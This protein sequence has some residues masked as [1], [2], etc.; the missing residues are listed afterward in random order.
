MLA[1]F[2][3]SNEFMGWSPLIKYSMK[4]ILTGKWE[5][6]ITVDEEKCTG[7]GLCVSVCP[8]RVFQIEDHK[9]KV[10]NRTN[11]EGCKACFIQCPKNAIIHSLQSKDEKCACVYCSVQDHVGE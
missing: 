4:M 1:A 7:C 8:V 3:V 11:C 10:I 9:S 6:E 2:Y 5:A